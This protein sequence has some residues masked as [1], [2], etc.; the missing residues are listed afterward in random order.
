MEAAVRTW[1]MTFIAIAPTAG[2]ARLATLVRV[3]AIPA[4]AAMEAPAMTTGMPFV[5]PAHLA[6]GEAPATQVSL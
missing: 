3:S 1:S 6:G 2:K 5:V 4:P